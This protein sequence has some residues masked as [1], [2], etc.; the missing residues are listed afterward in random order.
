MVNVADLFM[1]SE[2]TGRRIGFSRA[3]WLIFGASMVPGPGLSDHDVGG[4]GISM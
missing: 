2:S 4:R 3:R 1:V